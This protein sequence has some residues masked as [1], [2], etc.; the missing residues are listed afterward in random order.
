MIETAE[1]T[2][3]QGRIINV[4]SV[5][6]SWVKKDGFRFN[7]ILSG[8]KYNYL[9]LCKIITVLIALHF[10]YSLHFSLATIVDIMA[11]AL[12]LSQNWQIFCMPRK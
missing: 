10:R 9:V 4:S 2:G 7:D 6:H 11:H 1:K 12:M 3:I 8:K 5:I